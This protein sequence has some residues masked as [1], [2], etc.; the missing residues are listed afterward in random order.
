MAADNLHFDVAGAPLGLA[1]QVA[2]VAQRKAVAWRVDQAVPRVGEVPPRA[3]RL[4][5]YWT[6]SSRATALPAPLEGDALVAFVKAWLDTADYGSE[7]DIDGESSR[8]CRVYNEDWG[9]V[10]HEWQAFA[11]IEPYWLMHG[12]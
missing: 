6:E 11:A 12:K 4:V 5:L 3:P 1:L 2:A 9:Q 8:G 10:D 7:P